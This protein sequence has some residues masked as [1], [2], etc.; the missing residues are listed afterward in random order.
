MKVLF[1]W[2]N[3]SGEGTIP[4]GISS[5]SAYLKKHGHDTYL[6]DT[7]FFRYDKGVMR[8]YREKI[9]I[10]K[11]AD[12]ETYGVKY[13]YVDISMKF[14]EKIDDCNP[15]LIAFSATSYAYQSGV[16][17]LRNVNVKGARV[18]FGGP[19]ATAGPENAIQPDE[20][21]FICVGEGEEALLELCGKLENGDDVTNIRN[22]WSKNNGRIYKNSL[23]PATNLDSLP[24]PDN[25]IFSDM[26]YYKPFVGKVYRMGFIESTR[27]CPN[28]CT[29]CMAKTFN[30][31]YD[32]KYLRRKSIERVI[33]EL[34]YLKEEHNIN[35][36]RF[37]DETFLAVSMER[38]K[39]LSEVY[40]KE[41]N[42][43]FLIGTRPETF[44]QEKVDILKDMGCVSISIGIESGNA[45]IRREILNRKHTNEQVVKA[46][47]LAKKAGMR[48]SA[49]IMIGL[50]TEKR[51]NILETIELT[52]RVKADSV[53]MSYFMPYPGTKLRE[54]C[55]ERGYLDENA[56]V[57]DKSDGSIL[58]LPTITKEELKGLFETYYLY[59]KAPKWMYPI[60]EMTEKGKCDVDK[61]HSV[62]IEQ[63]REKQK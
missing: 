38:F 35:M 51:D 34:V 18:I 5:L 63:F 49:F 55:I 61:L 15:D 58:N 56:P 40:K 33:E 39:R 27:G 20:V 29:Y 7:T 45:R 47:D 28:A 3:D 60:I 21:E 1:V 19:H 48:T 16:D 54:Y 42:L 22:I 11:K 37:W 6:F 26:H 4:L 17:I 30:E 12:L 23:R 59:M 36:I 2:I 10:I 52:R 53:G 41:V 46:F 13:E 25:S 44:N 57:I 62:L 8:E 50:P 24:F 32:K 14:Q 9:G 43:P 31:K